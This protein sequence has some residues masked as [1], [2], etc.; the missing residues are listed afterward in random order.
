MALC[1]LKAFFAGQTVTADWRVGAA[2]MTAVGVCSFAF[3]YKPVRSYGALN[4]LG[5]LTYGVYLIHMPVISIGEHWG[6]SRAHDTLLLFTPFFSIVL[7]S[8]LHK[9]PLRKFI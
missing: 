6:I 7:T 4:Y 1:R 2:H 9:T 8:L 5:K 3:S